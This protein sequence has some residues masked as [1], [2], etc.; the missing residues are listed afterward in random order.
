MEADTLINLVKQ[1][2]TEHQM[3]YVDCVRIGRD[4]LVLVLGT[5]S[6]KKL[7]DCLTDLGV[8]HST[9][10]AVSDAIGSYVSLY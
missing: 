10:M 7:K 5:D 8:E 1:Y 3:T 4:I 2:C 6:A 9:P